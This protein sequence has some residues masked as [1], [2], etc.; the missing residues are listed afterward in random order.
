[1][2]DIR[3]CEGGNVSGVNTGGEILNKYH[4]TAGGAP[5]SLKHTVINP[6]EFR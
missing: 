5:A 6:S 2:S 3:V 4:F 1:M